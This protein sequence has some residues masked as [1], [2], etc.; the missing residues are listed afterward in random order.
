M[1]LEKNVIVIAQGNLPFDG[2][3]RRERPW[4][5][6]AFEVTTAPNLH[7]DRKFV[8]VQRVRVLPGLGTSLRI[9]CI[10]LGIFGVDVDQLDDEVCVSAGGGRE[11]LGGHWA[12]D[13]QVLL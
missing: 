8:A 11:E 9:P 6:I 7:R 3:I 10:L 5:F 4:L 2:S 1:S 13:R 12:S